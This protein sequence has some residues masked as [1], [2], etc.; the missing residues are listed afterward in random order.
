MVICRLSSVVRPC[1]TSTISEP[2]AWIP[3]KF[4]LLLPLE[5]YAGPIFEF[6]FYYFLRIPVFFVFVNMGPCGSQNFKTGLGS[7]PMFKFLIPNPI[8]VPT[9][10][11]NSNSIPIPALITK[12]N[13]N[14]F[15]LNSKSIPIPTTDF[16][17][18]ILTY[19]FHAITHVTSNS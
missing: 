9:E 7:I 13:S 14:S 12:F 19:Y 15:K 1:V 17:K 4:W 2:I 11:F 16:Y 8:P 10:K 18:L 5:P 6:F 3:L